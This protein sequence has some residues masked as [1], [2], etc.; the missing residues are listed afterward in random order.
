MSHCDLRGA[1]LGPLSLAGGRVLP[2]NLSGANLRYADLRQTDIAL[3]SREAC[4]MAYVRID[5]A[6]LARLDL[7]DDQARTA[8]TG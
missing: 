8:L 5:A 4:Q 6:V 1:D 7:P 2:V 3:A